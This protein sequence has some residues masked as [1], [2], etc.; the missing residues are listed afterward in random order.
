MTLDRRNFLTACSRAGITS[1]LLPGILYTLAT[2]AQEAANTDQSKPPKIT[3]EMI[4][5]ASVLAGI[6]PFTAEQKKMMIDGL[7]DQ[8]GS[9]K[10]IRK[11]KMANSV[12]PAFVF[13]PLP[14][15]QPI[16]GGGTPCPKPIG[17]GRDD[18]STIPDAPARIEDLA[19][20]T[21][22]DLGGLLVN[23]KVTSLA[24]TQMYLAR[25]KRYDSKLHFVITL[26]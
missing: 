8:N 5:Q 16:P 26:T 14:A 22:A 23:R 15:L 19:F 20:A 2:Q 12:A 11:L 18:L 10:A 6:G 13:H 17:F 24:L 21:I 4:D 7:V 9:M 1:A 3:P 25:L